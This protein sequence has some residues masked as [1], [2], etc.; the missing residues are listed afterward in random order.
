MGRDEGKTRTGGTEDCV[1]SGRR[2]PCFHEL[3]TAPRS[4]EYLPSPISTSCH[5]SHSE[6]L[7]QGGQI[8]MDAIPVLRIPSKQY[9]KNTTQSCDNLWHVT[10]R[11]ICLPSNIIKLH[12]KHFWRIVQTAKQ[13]GIELLAEPQV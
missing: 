3:R 10:F 2:C 4:K 13:H 9:Y 8:R 7:L 11:I 5:A 6:G 1:W 12:N